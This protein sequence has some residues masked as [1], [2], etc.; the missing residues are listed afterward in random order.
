MHSTTSKLR[1]TLARAP[2]NSAYARHI[3]KCLQY[4]DFYGGSVPTAPKGKTE[5]D[6]LEQ[7]FEFLRDDSNDNGTGNNDTAKEIAK[8]YYE[9]LF[10]EFALIDL[11]RWREGQVALRWRTKQEVL[12][13]LG[14]FTCASLTCPRHAAAPT[15]ESIDEFRLDDTSTRD[16]NK[17]ETGEGV[18]LETFEMNFGYMEKGVKKNALV[19][20]C[21]CE[22]CAGKL[23]RVKEGRKDD[24]RR[25]RRRSR[26]RR[27][28]K[29]RR[30]RRHRDESEE[31]ASRTRRRKD[32]EK[33]RISDHGGVEDSGESSRRHKSRDRHHRSDRRS[34]RKD[35][36]ER[37]HRSN[38]KRTSRSR[39]PSHGPT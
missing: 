7:E 39:S 38:H 30:H 2:R 3:Q 17:S 35:E 26:D 1:E 20:V 10:R 18:G 25:E 27:D 13:G 22:K 34:S 15:E 37:Y 6:L 16:N 32:D 21:V 19:K 5:R 14:Q 28:S 29:D 23:R 4:V 31:H 33:E 12:Q 11:S 36:S 9:N 8:K 24:D